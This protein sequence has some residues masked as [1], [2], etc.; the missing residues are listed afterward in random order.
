VVEVQQASLLASHTA[1]LIETNSL[2][3]ELALL[4]KDLNRLAQAPSQN[5]FALLQQQI[6]QLR[7]ELDCEETEVAAL[8]REAARWKL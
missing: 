4:S 2:K 8:R 7:K 1:Q 5:E 6:Q 3:A